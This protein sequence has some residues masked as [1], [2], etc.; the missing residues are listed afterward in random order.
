MRRASRP[1]RRRCLRR[2]RPVVIAGNGVRIAQ[3][4]DQLRRAGRGRRAAGG[5]DR[6]RQG[7]LRRN[8]SAGAGRVRHLRHRGGQR[9][10]RRGRP[11]AGIGTKLSAQRHGLG[12][13][14]PARPDP[15]DV[16][17]DRHRAAQRVVE[18]PGRTCAD[19]RCRACVLR[20]LHRRGRARR[21]PDAGSRPSGGSPRMARAAR[22]LRRAAPISPTTARCCRSA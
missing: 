15:A 1:P 11:R 4:Y 8:P 7:L 21:R 9:L 12:E 20:Q 14:R 2:R 19:R 6:G 18:F 16:H 5:D 13:P 22:L 17:P 10:R 3:A